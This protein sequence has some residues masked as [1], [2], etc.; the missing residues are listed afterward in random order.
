MARNIEVKS[1]IDSVEDLLPR[2]RALAG[3]D[4]QHIEQD[5]TV[6]TCAN[7]RLKLRGIGDQQRL[8][9]LYFDLLAAM[10]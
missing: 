6:F 9:G 4:A 5:D 7:G 1:R 3:G 2:I 8:A 10:R